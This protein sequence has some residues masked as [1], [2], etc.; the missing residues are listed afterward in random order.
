EID[1]IGGY[2]VYGI[3]ER[4]E[5]VRAENLL[6][7]GL[8]KGAKLLRDIK[9]DQLISCDKVKLDESLFMLVLRGLQDR[10]G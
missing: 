7:L 5:I 10:F 1:D 2:T 9:K 3:I 8:A 6:P 4:A